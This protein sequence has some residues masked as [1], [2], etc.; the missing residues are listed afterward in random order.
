M[1][2]LVLT[3]LPRVRHGEARCRSRDRKQKEFYRFVIHS[4]L[5]KT[6]HTMHSHMGTTQVNHEAERKRRTVGKY[7]YHGIY[8]KEWV[9]RG[10]QA[11][12]CLVWTASASSG[13]W[14]C[15]WLSVL[16]PGEIRVGLSWLKMWKA[17]KEGEWRCRLHQ[18]L[19]READW[20]LAQ[21]SN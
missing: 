10:K 16:A 3:I 18:L 13:H 20:S 12:D 5:G 4:S 11:Q 17:S 14:S 6:Q 9:R 15:P 7:L 19:R 21:I 1:P 8:R 2:L